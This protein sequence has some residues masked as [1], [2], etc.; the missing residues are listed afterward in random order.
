MSY[1]EP[2]AVSKSEN[3]KEGEKGREASEERREDGKGRPGRK[4]EERKRRVGEEQGK[5]NREESG[6]VQERGDIEKVHK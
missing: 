5:R 3:L 1:L 2:Q 6:R 4:R